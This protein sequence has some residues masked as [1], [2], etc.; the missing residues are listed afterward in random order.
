M[1]LKRWELISV[2][3]LILAGVASRFLPHAVN[4]TPILGLAIFVGHMSRRN[5]LLVAFMVVLLVV[6]DLAIGFY[7]GISL[8]YLSYA[9][10]FGFG[11][12]IRRRG[13]KIGAAPILVSGLSTAILFFFFS[14]L[15]VWLWS[16]MYE[17]SLTGIVQCYALALPF[18]PNVVISTLA[19]VA[20]TFGVFAATERLAA[21]SDR[22]GEGVLQEVTG[23]KR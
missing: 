20:L 17:K 1:E 19:T 18:F 14:N 11:Y 8:V 22:G 16:G 23:Q 6:S 9:L 10:A 4:F 2:L 15:G 7:D 3:G 21:R 13:K 5:P 12:L